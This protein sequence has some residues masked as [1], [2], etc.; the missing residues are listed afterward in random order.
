[1]H[2]RAKDSFS[3]RII[4]FVACTARRSASVQTSVTITRTPTEA[5]LTPDVE[6][7]T[8]CF[9]VDASRNAISLSAVAATKRDIHTLGDTTPPTIV[10][11]SPVSGS[12]G[13]SVTPTLEF[14]FDEDIV[15][16]AGNM[17]ITDGVNSLT[18]TIHL[19]DPDGTLSVLNQVLTFV[20]SVSTSLTTSTAYRVTMDA[21]LVRDSSD[22]AFAGLADHVYT[23]TTT[24]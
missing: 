21:G 4:I 6:Y 9:A 8:Y 10:A 20:P 17:V 22:I 19:T 18:I 2:F 23:F 5:S 1:M 13:V 16:G 7:D 12:L 3:K 11:F 24:S 15:V 14:T